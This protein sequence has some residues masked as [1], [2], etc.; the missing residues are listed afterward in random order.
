MK[1]LFPEQNEAKNETIPTLEEYILYFK[2]AGGG[3][4][5]D[6]LRSHYHR[7]IT[8]FSLLKPRLGKNKCVLDVGAHWLHQSL[9][10]SLNGHRVFAAQF[11]DTLADITVKKI[12]ADNDI[13]I[14]EYTSLEN[15]SV[16]SVLRENEIDCV[17]FTEVL[18]HITFNPISFWK[19]IYRVLSPGGR[20]VITTPNYYAVREMYK[21]IP[22]FVK[23][24]GGGISIE[25]ILGTNTYGH[26]WKLYSAREIVE[27]FR[28]LS[29]DFKLSF[30]DYFSAQNYFHP[31]FMIK[32]IITRLERS[33][34][35]LRFNLYIEIELIRKEKG[36]KAISQ[37]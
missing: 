12:A 33:V 18:E 10:Y 26:H 2:K 31:N 29:D 3:T 17:L 30:L 13:T 22:R 15:E 1:K 24:Y 4:D 25:E 32:G 23:G 37:W 6:Y 5:L 34:K 8:T 9:L 36:I 7:F 35:K 27:Y 28:I 19:E 14:I 16:F 21:K 20:I 11:P